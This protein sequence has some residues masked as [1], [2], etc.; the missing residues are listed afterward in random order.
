LDEAVRTLAMVAERR[1]SET[2]RV[3]GGMQ[4]EEIMIEQKLDGDAESAGFGMARAARY[5]AIL[6]TALDCPVLGHYCGPH[7]NSS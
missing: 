1:A 5:R 2:T 7:S 3:N 4:T 6:S